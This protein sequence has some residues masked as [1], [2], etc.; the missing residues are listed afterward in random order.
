MPISTVDHVGL[1]LLIPCEVASGSGNVSVG[2]STLATC[3][4]LRRWSQD[5]RS[6]YVFS[7]ERRW[8]LGTIPST[9]RLLVLGFELADHSLGLVVEGGETS[10]GFSS[11]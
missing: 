7:G 10:S 11:A 4:V 3:P 2:R 5:M 9:A 8:P 1:I 6:W